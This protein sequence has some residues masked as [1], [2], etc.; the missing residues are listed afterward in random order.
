MGKVVQ[1]RGE[2]YNGNVLGKGGEEYA[3]EGW[4]L[5]RAV[6]GRG[7]MEDNMRKGS[8]RPPPI[9]NGVPN[10][11]KLT[12][13]ISYTVDSQTAQLTNTALE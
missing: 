11:C 9:G 1:K 4:A 12:L 10:L 2:G 6:L 8:R 3:G 7:L 5:E 13:C